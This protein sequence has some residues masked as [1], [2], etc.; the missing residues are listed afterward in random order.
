MSP[1]IEIAP[2]TIIFFL[3]LI[4]TLLILFLVWDLLL[5]L[6]VAFIIFATLSPGVEALAKK[7]WPRIL[8]VLAVTLGLIM[9]LVLFIFFGLIPLFFRL[10]A[11][12]ETITGVLGQV[13]EMPFL[14]FSVIEEEVR[15]LVAE[16]LAFVVGVFENFLSV[17][18]VLVIAIYLLVERQRYERLVSNIT[19]KPW[20]ETVFFR[21]ERQLGAWVRGES[22][23]ALFVGLLYFIVL[24]FIGIDF[25]LS[26]AVLGAIFE[27][28][29]IFGP[30]I[31]AIP[32][33][34]LGLSVSPFTAIVII[35]AYT[36]IQQLESSLII[37][38]VIGGVVGLDPLL[39]ILSV[40][41]FGRLFGL[42]GIFLAVPIAVVIRAFFEEYLTG[43]RGRLS[44]WFKL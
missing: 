43:W 7:G 22:L 20:S 30:I 21:V 4:L 40:V 23:A 15:F 33:V 24:S 27:F 11:L 44:A 16:T 14:N 31:A 25:A 26:L 12:A 34:L 3:S 2:Q 19:A 18:S 9:I 42:G 32:A 35:L 6:F 17:L 39:V 29:P 28:V 38:L 13:A 8:A 1:R 5:L 36:I 10:Q 41:F 37:P